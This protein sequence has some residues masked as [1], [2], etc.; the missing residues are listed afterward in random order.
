MDRFWS[1]RFLSFREKVVVLGGG[2]WCCLGDR[3]V[4]INVRRPSCV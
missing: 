2:A 1:A 4:M 3:G